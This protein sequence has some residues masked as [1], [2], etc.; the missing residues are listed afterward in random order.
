MNFSPLR[1]FLLTALILITPGAAF[2]DVFAYD[3]IRNG[4][5]VGQGLV[6]I[7]PYR[8][9]LN[10][11]YRMHI[12][13]KIL[14]IS[15]YRLDSH[16]V[17]FFDSEGRLIFARTSAHIDGDDNDVTVVAKK[18]QYLVTHNN[19]QQEYS[20]DDITTTTLNPLFQSP[21]S[22]V[23]LDLSNA[24]LVRYEVSQYPDS[25]FIKRPDGSDRLFFDDQGFVKR[26]ESSVSKGSLQL[27]RIAQGLEAQRAVNLPNRVELSL[28]ERKQIDQRISLGQRLAT[29][30]N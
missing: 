13:V 22:G 11:N 25:Y 9:G 20:S 15:F 30:L 18:E 4:S 3:V 19:R 2:S 16:Q 17:A 14:G 26:V 27:E 24:E 12:N 7:L 6:E 23:Y 8:D 5:K 1:L 21:S 10:V 29:I 28:A